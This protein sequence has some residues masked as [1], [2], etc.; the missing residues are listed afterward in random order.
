M[1]YL[2]PQHLVATLILL[3]ASNNLWAQNLNE[4]LPSSDTDIAPLYPL[5]V[6]NNGEPLANMANI[7]GFGRTFGFGSS[8]TDTLAADPGVIANSFV[9]YATEVWSNGHANYIEKFSPLVG[10]S[11]ARG[12]SF[13]SATN[14]A[15][16]GTNS[17]TA[18]PQI[19][20]FEAAYGRFN[21]NDVVVMTSGINDFS[22][23]N[24]AT[25]AAT[26]LVTA[27]N[28]A[29]EQANMVRQFID[30][31][32]Q[33]IF[34]T[35]LPDYGTFNYFYR[36]GSNNDPTALTLGADATNTQLVANLVEIQKETGANIHFFNMD[37]SIRQIRANPTAYGF[38]EA[39]VQSGASCVEL[40]TYFTTGTLADCGS[41][42][43]A[44]QNQY[45]SL[46]GIHYTDRYHNL[47]AA[48]MANQML[49]PYSMAAQA[50][51][52]RSSNTGFSDALG[53][54][55]DAK[56]S[57]TLAKSSDVNL[58]DQSDGEHT[59]YLQALALNGQ[60]SDRTGASGS[61]YSATGFLAGLEKQLSPAVLGGLALSYSAPEADLNNALGSIDAKSYQ[62][63]GYLSWSE[64]ER[65]VD[66][67]ATVGMHDLKTKRAGLISDL[68]ASPEGKSITLD[69]KMGHL[70]AL[71]NDENTTRIGPILGA[72]YNHVDIDRYS[73]SGDALL[74]QTAYKQTLNS[75]MGSIGVGVR[76]PFTAG[77]VNMNAWADITLDHEFRDSNRRIKSALRNAPDLPIT[78]VVASTAD[79]HY[80]L[81]GGFSANVRENISI[82]IGGNYTQAKGDS[83]TNQLALTTGVKL[84]W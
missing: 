63:G 48:A 36:A 23:A 68:T 56:R 15:R 33:N 70:F 5:S 38:T 8:S 29:T 53:R 7:T 1:K 77:E 67:T 46:D 16:A 20:Q 27:A 12:S 58:V 55:L 61:D 73:E 35:N 71:S 30:L 84:L 69:A 43:F 28:D 62:L 22:A 74:N 25:D 50:D 83:D 54:R 40:G 81:A 59:F 9:P 45:L 24:S 75:L 60:Q 37:L 41:A 10:S 47:W 19:A 31:G 72:S 14:F 82:N 4:Y 49:A 26:A 17:V 32:A 64:A 52:I 42:S 2:E 57:D 3:S 79:T 6:P 39:G 18:L 11:N 78:T 44:T 80:R 21:A 65:F 34:V 66:V 76:A 13:P 51:L